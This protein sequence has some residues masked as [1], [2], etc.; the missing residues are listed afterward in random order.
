MN[1]D[2]ESYDSACIFK[3]I[4]SIDAID[5][6]TSCN[7]NIT[8]LQIINGKVLHMPAVFKLYPSLLSLGL[9]SVEISTIDQQ[10]FRGGVNLTEFNLSNS[11]VTTLPENFL[12]DS[13]LLRSLNLG[14]NRIN[15]IANGIFHVFVDLG[16]LDLSVND[17]DH[18]PKDA[19]NGLVQLNTIRLNG[20]RIGVIDKEFFVTNA[21]LRLIDLSGNRIDAIDP[22]T[23]EGLGDL[24][25]LILDGNP[26]KSINLP[27]LPHLKRL[28]VRNT[29]LLE[30][31][32]PNSAKEVFA[33]GNFISRVHAP[34]TCIVETLM[35]ANNS[36][37][38]LDEF[39]ALRKLEMLDV[40]YNSLGNVDF[41]KLQN[42]TKLKQLLLFGN[43][44]T[45]IRP[46]E[47]R[48]YL[49][50]LNIIE[51]TTRMW[52]R[53]YSDQLTEGFKKENIVVFGD[54]RK[55]L[56]Q[57]L[58]GEVPYL[59]PL[60]AV[61]SSPDTSPPIPAPTSNDVVILR[62]ELSKFSKKISDLE[63]LVFELRTNQT[64]E[65]PS[66]D[67]RLVNDSEVKSLSADVKA[68]KI[69]FF[70]FICL[71]VTATVFLFVRRKYTVVGN[72]LTSTDSDFNP[73]FEERL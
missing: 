56:D 20:N 27:T 57:S 47:V 29:S 1:C 50:K 65:K 13:P 39:P 70:I 15:T 6:G 7:P 71:L 35:L 38:G 25:T 22:A 53:S 72:R 10:S 41:A 42:L 37:G 23:F 58:P 46:S 3:S 19:I 5:F 30:L 11:T 33:E 66:T 24:R 8:L 55:V 34:S 16:T 44:I 45:L 61:D 59:T 51:L 14:S 60:N 4:A 17:I 48:Q 31:S 2:V 52:N 63:D 68:I 54:D 62:A 69:G 40:S 26:I 21:N 73:I 64:Q 12:L 9:N 49:P 36:L 28:S 18:L 67:S 32:L 43:K